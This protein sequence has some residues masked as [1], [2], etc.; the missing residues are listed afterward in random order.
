M[1]RLL[2]L[3]FLT[4]QMG[5]YAQK[6]CEYSSNFTDSIGS[7]K[8][9]V[10]KIV[11]EKNFAGTSS[12]IFFSLIN[13]NGTPLLNFQNIQKSKDFIK[14]YCF[15]KNSR[16]YLQ[17]ANGKIITMLISDEGSCGSMIRDEAQS[18]NIR[19]STGAFLF[20]KNTMEEL[21]K[22]P[23]TLIRIK[24]ASETVDYIMK[25][26]LTSELNGEKSYPENFFIDH[27]K[28]LN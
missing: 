16:V 26:E 10:Q 7:Y 23:I 28:C 20:M 14:A 19:I 21:E 25:K 27:L 2:I 22:S 13:A 4:L 12:Y 3:T 1:K 24:Y 6:S 18:S 11:Y 17:L 8:E 9:T 5:V 15:D